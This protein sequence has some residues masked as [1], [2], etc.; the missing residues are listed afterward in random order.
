VVIKDREKERLHEYVESTNKALSEHIKQLRKF[1]M[2]PHGWIW[3][4]DKV[5]ELET[6][7]EYKKRRTRIRI[8]TGYR[9]KKAKE[10]KS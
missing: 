10:E 1:E 4:E 3:H 9:E 6:I 7:D 5:K 2:L 8:C